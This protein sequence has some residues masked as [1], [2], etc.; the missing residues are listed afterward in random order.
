MLHAEN[1]Y[2]CFK[3]QLELVCPGSPHGRCSRRAVGGRAR[4]RSRSLSR[5]R[6]ARDEAAPPGAGGSWESRTGWL[7]EGL[8]RVSA[9]RRGALEHIQSP[10]PSVLAAER[11]QMRSLGWKAFGTLPEC[12]R[13]RLAQWCSRDHEE[14]LRITAVTWL[15]PHLLPSVSD[16]STHLK[17]S[18]VPAWCT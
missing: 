10:N 5:S 18:D 14:N 3:R 8:Q 17:R 6:S 2:Q 4:S 11:C 1:S 7:L 12:V 16:L 9:Y 13:T 15:L